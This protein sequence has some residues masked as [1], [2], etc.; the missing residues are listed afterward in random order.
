MWEYFCLLSWTLIIRDQRSLWC[1][2]LHHS[3]RCLVYMIHIR[4]GVKKIW[5]EFSIEGMTS[6]IG[7]KAFCYILHLFKNGRKR[8]KN[9]HC[10]NTHLFVETLHKLHSCKE[11]F[12]I[13]FHA[14]IHQQR[15]ISSNESQQSRF[16]INRYICV[17]SYYLILANYCIWTVYL[18]QATVSSLPQ[19]AG[20]ILIINL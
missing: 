6:S 14:T 2:S 19:P 13:G 11:K 17:Y 18:F 4:E 12:C 8:V 15:E 10:T 9:F 3:N 1:F 16:L 5:T 20:L 7:F